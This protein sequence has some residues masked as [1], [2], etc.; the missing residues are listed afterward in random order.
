MYTELDFATVI[1][2]GLRVMDSTAIAH[3]MEHNRPVMVFNY[4]REGNIQRAIAGERLGTLISGKAE[5]VT[6]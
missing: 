6:I 4:L 1:E 2:K 3:C 5:T